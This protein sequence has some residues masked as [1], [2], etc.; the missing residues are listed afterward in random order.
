MFMGVG[1]LIITFLGWQVATLEDTSTEFA[2]PFLGSLALRPDY[3]DTSQPTV[4]ASADV[5]EEYRT[6]IKA[7]RASLRALGKD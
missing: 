5:K 4:L 6:L 2:L 3:R 1:A 7:V